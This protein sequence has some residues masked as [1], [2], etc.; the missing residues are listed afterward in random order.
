VYLKASL[1][2]G[3]AEATN[4]TP[5]DIA[6]LNKFIKKFEETIMRELNKVGNITST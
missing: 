3:E 6:L 4:I 1:D 5:E 2:G